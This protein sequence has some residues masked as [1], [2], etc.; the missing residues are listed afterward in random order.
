MAKKQ[1]Q[2]ATLE[3]ASFANNAHNEYIKTH[4][5]RVLYIRAILGFA[6]FLLYIILIGI[7]EGM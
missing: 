4:E 6:L 5:I 3:V 7:V 1:K 2:L